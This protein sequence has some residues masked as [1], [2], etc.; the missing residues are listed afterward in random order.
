MVTIH[1]HRC[2]G[3][4]GSPDGTTYRDVPSATPAAVPHSGLCVCGHALVY[5]PQPEP[6]PHNSRSVHRLRSASRN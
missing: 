1:C 6:A 4:I 2:G 5:G 3:F